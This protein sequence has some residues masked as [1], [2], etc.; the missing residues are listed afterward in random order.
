[1]H[2]YK[3]EEQKTTLLDYS[4]PEYEQEIT[5]NFTPCSIF[6]EN[7][8]SAAAKYTQKAREVVSLSKNRYPG[9]PFTETEAS[10]EDGDTLTTKDEDKTAVLLKA[11]LEE[12]ENIEKELFY[13]RNSIY[14]EK[15]ENLEKELFS[16]EKYQ[17]KL[18][19]KAD[20]EQEKIRDKRLYNAKTFRSAQ[21]VAL[22]KRFENDLDAINKD[23]QTSEDNIRKAIISS[24]PSN[25]HNHKRLKLNQEAI[26]KEIDKDK[27]KNKSPS[28]P[29]PSPPP[30]S[31][32]PSLTVTPPLS[33]TENQTTIAIKKKISTFQA[34]EERRKAIYSMKEI[35]KKA[36]NVAD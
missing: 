1:M 27:D 9:S 2:K 3:K 26:T 28:P 11:C 36:F 7:T 22:N 19:K 32:S 10:S 6:Y 29:P 16:I 20:K 4:L 35:N 33:S 15:L 21:L 13:H 12:V 31:P 25:H 14:K 30:P 24:M 18:I 17:H 5:E 34:I 23:V 8:F